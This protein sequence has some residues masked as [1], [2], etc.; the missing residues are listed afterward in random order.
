MNNRL[1][2]ILSYVLH[3]AIYPLLGVLAAI[4]FVPFSVSSNTLVLTLGLVFVGTYVLPVCI[5]YLLFKMG[6]ILSLE[7]KRAKDR[8]IPYLIGALC[9]YL[10]AMLV[11]QIQLPTEVYFYLLAATLVIVIHLLG[12][13]FF[14]PS[15][16]LAGIGGLTGLLLALSIKYSINLLPFLAMAFFLAGLLAS[17]RLQ[18]KAHTIKEVISGYFSG[19]ILVAVMVYFS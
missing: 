11:E 13:L 1:A 18:L 8:R 4:Q 6:I 12:L 3:P 14:K 9:Y 5:S 7:M 2:T 19:V 10:V 15:A 16:H 17:A